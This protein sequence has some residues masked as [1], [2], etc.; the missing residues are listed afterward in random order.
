MKIEKIPVGYLLTKK[1]GNSCELWRTFN[2]AESFA[3]EAIDELIAER[4]TLR[5]KITEMEKQEPIGW[6]TED[7]QAD[8]SATTYNYETAERWRNKG[9]PVS[10]LYALPGAQNVPSVPDQKD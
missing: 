7:Y 3:C 2:G 4:D 9:W 6:V 1:G 8:K 10:N 5:A